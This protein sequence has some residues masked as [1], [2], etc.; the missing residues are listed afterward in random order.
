MREHQEK[1]Q[2]TESDHD[3]RQDQRLRHRVRIRRDQL[4][5]TLAHDWWLAA[6][7]SSD[8]ENQQV[9]TVR[10]QAQADDQLGKP[11]APCRFR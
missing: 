4:L 8:G 5:R 2:Q 6:R 11:A 3:C 9:G 7:Q 10:Q 1:R